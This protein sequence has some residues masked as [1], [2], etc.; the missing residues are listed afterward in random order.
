VRTGLRGVPI[1]RSQPPPPLLFRV[2]CPAVHPPAQ[3]GPHSRG[4][5]CW[6]PTTSPLGG[7]AGVVTGRRVTG[8]WSS[9]LQAE[10]AQAAC[11]RVCAFCFEA[12]L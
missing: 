6:G 11:G 4:G 3:S 1:D 9:R 5:A 7:G 8:K 12:G 10:A 2:Q